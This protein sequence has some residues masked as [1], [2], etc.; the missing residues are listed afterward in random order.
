ME[1]W[2]RITEAPPIEFTGQTFEAREV[3]VSDGKYV[4]TT[5]YHVGG[6]HIGKPWGS[7]QSCDGLAGPITHWHPKPPPPTI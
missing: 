7:F 2:V 1:S 6:G 4:C 3:W 5:E